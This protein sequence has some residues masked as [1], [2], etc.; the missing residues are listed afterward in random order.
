LNYS[1]G[2]HG[3]N[4]ITLSSLKLNFQ[5]FSADFLY[6]AVDPFRKIE[7]I[8]YEQLVYPFNFMSDK[9]IF[10][11]GEIYPSVI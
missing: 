6:S 2:C 5:A 9:K 7:F 11:R 10:Y 3:K 1:D 4:S 8:I